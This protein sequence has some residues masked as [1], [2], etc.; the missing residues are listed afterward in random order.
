MIG[1][2]AINSVMFCVVIA[3][4]VLGWLMHKQN[5]REYNERD[6]KRRRKE[7]Y[8]MVKQKR[9]KGTPEERRV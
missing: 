6:N 5:L 2:F 4:V 3:T 8:Y 7:Y 9:D 1:L